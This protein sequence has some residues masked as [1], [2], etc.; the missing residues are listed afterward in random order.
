MLIEI[1]NRRK[2]N[3]IISGEY[4]NIKDALEK[5]RG[6]NL[7][8]ADLSGANLHDANLRYADLR[9][10]DL[11]GA[12]LHDANLSGADLSDANLSGAYLRYANLHDAYL[13][14]ANLRYADLSYANLSGVN[15]RGANFSGANLDMSCLPLQCGSLTIKTEEKQRIQIAFHLLSLIKHGDPTDEEKTFY[16]SMLEY[17][18]RFHRTDVKKLEKI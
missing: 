7:S 10:A 3:I 14:Y 15:L 9:Y 2:G 18:N 17:V 8:Y 1:K 11:S 16:N 5:N 13:R 12:N 4:D 6:V